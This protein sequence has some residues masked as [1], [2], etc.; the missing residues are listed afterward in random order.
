MLLHYLKCRKHAESKNPR[1][2]MVNKGRIRLLPKYA[3]F[4]CKKSRFFKT[5]EASRLSSNLGL[6]SPLSKIPLLGDI[7]FYRVLTRQYNL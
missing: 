4:D 7:L 1:V 6:R 2:A 3:V 5:Q